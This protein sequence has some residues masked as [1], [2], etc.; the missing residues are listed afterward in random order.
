M[1]KKLNILLLSIAVSSLALC[2]FAQAQTPTDFGS[3]ESFHI[4]KSW[5]KP[6]INARL[7]HR[8]FHKIS[9]TECYFAMLGGGYGFTPW[10][11]ADMGYEFWKIPSA[12]NATIH[13]A[14]LGATGTLKK[15]AL[16]VS[17]REKYELAFN[18][19]GGSPSGTLRSRLRAQY[20]IPSTPVTPYLMYEHF[21]TLGSA[22]GWQR[23][24]HYVGAEFKLGGPN[25]LDVY[26][27]YHLFPTGTGNASCNILGLC[28]MLVF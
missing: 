13:K 24:L 6:F 22:G 16:A 17:L 18:A 10:L 23:S 27:M 25:I 9:A 26:Y 7:E 4:V 19:A 11:K 1:R 8:S 20:S 12:G 15:D 3:W 21:Q 5:G 28:Y 14:T 2:S